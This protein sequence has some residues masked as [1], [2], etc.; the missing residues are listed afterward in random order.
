MLAS[1]CFPRDGEEVVVFAPRQASQGKK[2]LAG[3]LLVPK[4]TIFLDPTFCVL[5]RLLVSC[6]SEKLEA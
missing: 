6:R 4:G 5:T 1:A 2:R 3:A